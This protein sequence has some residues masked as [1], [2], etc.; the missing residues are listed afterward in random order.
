MSKLNACIVIISSRKK[1]IKDCLLSL[2]EKY[3]HEHDYP[4]YVH[5]FDDIY[6]DQD[7]RNDITNSCEQNVIFK[8]VPYNTPSF[9]KEEELYYNRKDLWYV[10][11]SFSINR[12]GYLHMCHFTS[13][14]LDKD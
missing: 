10:K 2:W 11:N 12:K 5:Y 3:N 4:V 13:N 1:C 6:D 14:M 9:L 7:F 8:S